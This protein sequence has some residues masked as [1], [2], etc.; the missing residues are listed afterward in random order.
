M[1]GLVYGG[2]WRFAM[3]CLISS[4]LLW[5]SVECVYY[6]AIV[7]ICFD[8][9]LVFITGSFTLVSKLFIDGVCEVVL[10]L[11]AKTMVGA[12]FHPLVAMLLMSG[13]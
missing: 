12:T 8:V 5:T 10:A 4:L 11:V 6:V 1:D 9:I 7:L 3:I 13:W 2:L